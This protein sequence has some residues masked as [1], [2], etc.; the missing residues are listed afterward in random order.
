[1]ITHEMV[2]LGF[3]MTGLRRRVGGFGEDD[4]EEEREET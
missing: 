1:M 4:Q 2:R 3:Q